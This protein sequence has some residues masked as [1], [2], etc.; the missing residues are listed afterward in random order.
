MHAQGPRRVR[1]LFPVVAG[2]AVLALAAAALGA[3]PAM[4]ATSTPSTTALSAQHGKALT[5]A[6]LAK[7]LKQVKS[8]PSSKDATSAKP[9]ALDR[10]KSRVDGDLADAKGTVTVMLELDATPAVKSYALNRSRGASAA[11]DAGRSQAATVR[12]AQSTVLTQISRPATKARAIYRVQNAYSGVA[13]VTDASRLQA[14]SEIP[15]VK[16]IHQMTLKTISNSSSVPLIGAPAAWTATSQ[17]GQGVKVG[18]IDTG[19][20]YTHKD[21]GGSGDVADYHAAQ[22]GS[23]AG[24]TGTPKVKGGYDFAGDDYDPG[25]TA[26]PGH[27]V[28]VPDSNPLDCN[29]HGSHVAG[30]AAGFGVTTAGATYAG[31]Y[32]ASVPAS[33]FSIGPGVAPQADLYALRVFG[34]EGSTNLVTPALDW[35]ADPNGDGNFADHLDVVNMSLG[36]SY[37]SPQDPDAV[38]SN[39]LVDIGTMVVA[40]IGNSG[41]VYEVGGSPGNAT[42]VL[43]VAASDDGNDVV[44]GLKIDE[45]AG[46][47]PASTV[48]GDQDNVFAALKS[49]AYDWATKPGVTD[50]QVVKVGDWTKAPSPT[51]NTDG[52][53]AYTPSE[54]T[55]I[56]GKI[57]L[58]FWTDGTDRRCGSVGRS[59]NAR[60]GGAAAAIF[61]ND[62]NSFSAGVTGDAT[63]PAMITVKQATDALVKALDLGTTVKA[64]MTNALRNSVQIITPGAVD[65]IA[66]FSSRGIGM[67]GNVKPDVAAPGVT[68]FSAAVGTGSEGVAESGTSMA[69]PHVTGEA[70]LVRQAH[71]T[72]SVEQVKAAIMNTATQDVYTGAGH[73]GDVYGPERVGAGRVKVDKAV[74]T[75][76]LAYVK[77]DPGA[78]SVS[79]GPIAAVGTTTRTKTVTIQNTG[80]A[81]ATYSLAYKAAVAA[82]GV[83]YSVS[84]SSVS[85]PAG[86][87]TDV[88]VTLL[89]DAAQLR[90]T[91]DPTTDGDPLGTGLQRSYRTDASGRLVL[92][93]TGATPAGTL[94][95]P[96]WSAPR[97]A[98][99]M[100]AQ[101]SVT[102]NGTGTVQTGE[103][104]LLGRS[105][106]QGRDA[107]A[108]ISTASAFQLQTSSPKLADCNGT[109][110]DDCVSYPDERGADLRYVGSASDAPVYIDSGLDP[111]KAYA[112]SA[113]CQTE[114]P[115]PDCLVPPA[116]VNFAVSSWGPWR[117]AAGQ[118]EF[119]VYIDGDGDGVEDAVTYNSRLTTATDDFDYFVTTTIDLH[120]GD[121]IDQQLVNGVDGSLET[122]LFNSDSMIMPVALHALKDAGLISRNEPIRYAVVSFSAG[123]SL[124]D[125]TDWM[126][127][128]VLSPGLSAS[129]DSGFS[130]L[131]TDNEDEWFDVRRDAT[132]AAT[133]KP[134]GLL[135]LHHLNADGARAQVV[136]VRTGTTT[137][138][139]SSATSFTYGARPTLTATVTPRA[140]AGTP[141]GTVT[142]KD[143]SK[144]LGTRTL[145]AG[146]ATFQVPVLGR[147]THSLVATYGGDTQNVAS[148]SAVVKVTVKGVASATKL[149][150]NDR[151]F[152]HGYRPT[153]TATVTTTATG[154]VTFRDGSKVIGS[155]TISKGKAVLKAPVLAKGT[156]SLKATYNGSS[157]YNP[158]TSSAV[159]VRVR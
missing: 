49:V 19:I 30:T 89:I 150:V 151:D 90:H 38:A 20:D 145:A 58:Q 113:S 93:A 48:D 149:A 94:R 140:A 77:G 42:K 154:T 133:D 101:S 2:S 146:K 36:S 46:I 4:A 155:A 81:T 80:G 64:T 106:F 11:R 45:P 109:P 132:T 59:Q 96:V 144:V 104:G 157:K 148:T 91:Q 73:T 120:T 143:G 83:T 134:L 22:N 82:S 98:S 103:A 105:L 115:N 122:G 116:M 130:T 41:D 56:A 29:G 152:S 110:A 137:R 63:I 118:I 79:F 108:Y 1:G 69:S 156:H 159:S 7:R 28:P 125:G 37:G 26:N 107:G 100:A 111:Y 8:A 25:N 86:S 24:W 14:L 142:F 74:A 75:T 53:T 5:R 34:C 57:V 99:A 70:A 68:T 32:N 84:P 117:T 78:V 10:G 136:S 131:N 158:S 15:G 35:A 114:S 141:T 54:Q 128:S 71:P 129:G 127:L 39:N 6:Q 119:Q 67:A 47:E 3:A 66:S 43:A 31:S 121:V 60:N 88:T 27:D 147:G 112:D 18:I 97:P 13:V 123:T 55:A 138:L 95:V 40:S 139:T 44:D 61:G 65:Q 9:F 51:N 126:T 16:A 85:V 87:S 135:L 21:F 23:Q 72:W 92:T 52:C 33:T 124:T 102:L 50:T 17:T 153:L 62:Q 76:T 12:R